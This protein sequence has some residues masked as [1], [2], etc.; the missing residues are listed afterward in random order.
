[1]AKKRVIVSRRKKLKEIPKKEKGF[2]KNKILIAFAVVLILMF[3]FS[4]IN[5]YSGKVVVTNL[6]LEEGE[7]DYINFDIKHT[8]SGEKECFAD[9]K[10]YQ[11]NKVVCSEVKSLGMLE[12]NNVVSESLFMPFPE[13]ET[14]FKV[15]I[16]CR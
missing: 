12:P 6:K 8:F 2:N 4:L 16:D 5:Q 11:D 7:K 1:M 3:L 13:G 14:D 15:D 9:I 10:I